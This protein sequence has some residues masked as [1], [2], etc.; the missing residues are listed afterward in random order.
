[1]VSI[2]AFAARTHYS[3]SGDFLHIVSL[4]LLPRCTAEDANPHAHLTPMDSVFHEYLSLTVTCVTYQVSQE[5][6]TPLSPDP[7]VSSSF[8]VKIGSYKS[9]SQVPFEV[10]WM[11]QEAYLAINDYVLKLY[12]INLFASDDEVEVPLQWP[13]LPESAHSKKVQYFP[14]TEDDPDAKVML[15]VGASNKPRPSLPFGVLVPSAHLGP[16]VSMGSIM[17]SP[18]PPHLSG[19]V[20]TLRGREAWEWSV[21]F[22]EVEIPLRLITE[23]D[24]GEEKVFASE[25][26]VLALTETAESLAINF[27]YH[28]QKGLVSVVRVDGNSRFTGRC[29]PSQRQ[30]IIALARGMGQIDQQRYPTRMSTF[31]PIYWLGEAGAYWVPWR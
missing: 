19:M 28:G 3:S 11:P 5:E 12:K 8:T 16:W 10:T 17:G 15:I 9:V 7:T 26:Y 22:G 31:A 2:P 14:P 4:A 24:G 1:M 20:L 30:N 29:G 18:S 21:T 13:A 23:K 27:Y 25:D 6:S